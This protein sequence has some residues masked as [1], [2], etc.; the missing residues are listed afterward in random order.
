MAA[1][2]RVTATDSA[3]ALLGEIAERHGPVLI[4]QSGGCCDGSSPMIY[5]RDE[6]RIGERDMLIGEI[7]DIPVYI[8]SAQ[9]AAWKHTQLVLDA[10]DGRGGMFSLDNG[11]ERRLLVRSRAFDDKELGM[12]DK[13]DTLRQMHHDIA[14]DPLSLIHI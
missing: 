5:P 8:G 2:L 4:H 6:F 9:F 7:G 1:P 14:R 11:T 12:I 3:R 13:A 10:V